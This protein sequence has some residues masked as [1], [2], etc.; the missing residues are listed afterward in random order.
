MKF[1]KFKIKNDKNDTTHNLNLQ[2]KT[3]HTL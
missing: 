1:Q 2:M 3:K